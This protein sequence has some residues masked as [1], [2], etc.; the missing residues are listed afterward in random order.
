[1]PNLTVWYVRMEWEQTHNPLLSCSLTR[2]ATRRRRTHSSFQ[3]RIIASRH[4]SRT[5]T[6][7]E[8]SSHHGVEVE[9]RFERPRRKVRARFQLVVV[10]TAYSPRG[11]DQPGA[12]PSPRRVA[13][14]SS[15]SSRKRCMSR[16][17]SSNTGLRT[18]VYS[19]CFSEAIRWVSG[20][21]ATVRLS[22][23]GGAES[24]NSCPSSS[25]SIEMVSRI[26]PRSE[27]HWCQ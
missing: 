7:S 12:L 18:A 8:G 11:T 21:E 5:C 15:S 20:S 4:A 19:A 16:P 3:S 1:M 14:S 13:S 27:S 24:G 26:L 10:R 2:F 25:C 22:L 23:T 17:S 6:G 9:V